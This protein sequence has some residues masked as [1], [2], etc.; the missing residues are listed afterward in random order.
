MSQG[1]LGGWEL[2]EGDDL[3]KA[4]DGLRPANFA[5]HARRA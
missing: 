2:G 5:Q 3:E 1:L 4:C